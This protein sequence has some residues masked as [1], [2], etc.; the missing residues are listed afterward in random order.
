MLEQKLLNK[1][2]EIGE[3]FH[4]HQTTG[5]EQGVL[6]GET[7]LALF[8][9]YFSKFSKDETFS[10][11]G[12]NILEKSVEKV[13]S[14]YSLPT[15][16]A[17]I[18]GAAWVF[19]HLES[20]GFLAIDNDEF[21]PDLDK[22]IFTSMMVDIK[23]GNYDFLHGSLGNSY[24]FFYRFKNTKSKLLKEKYKDGILKFI[25]ELERISEFE[26]DRIKW[27]TKFDIKNNFTTY[28]LSLSHGISSIINFLSLLYTFE[29]FR[30]PVEKILLGSIN[31]V[32]SYYNKNRDTISLFPSYIRQN[33]DNQWNTR[34]AWCYGDL[35]IGL[36]LWKASRALNDIDLEKF[37]IDILSHTA[38]R[39]TPSNT[40]VNDSG[41]CH[42]SFGNAQV[43]T[44]LFRQTNI[45]EFQKS[46]QFWIEDGLNKLFHGDENAGHKKFTG[47][48]WEKELSLLDGIAGI[49]LAIMS[50]LDE[51][52]SSWDECLMIT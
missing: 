17:G 33:E 8:L 16:C 46:A 31:F 51:D 28:N 27:A 11:I 20:H 13:N 18:S 42:G 12:L 4:K 41:L 45:I 35:G 32:L 10:D 21:L 6:S 47:I 52:F 5:N 22:H 48:G 29:E 7:G 23:S 24:Y 1:L 49:G 34:V 50:Y 9:F 37:S 40:M 39:N 3:C 43:F 36:S 25:E 19:N 38:S 30:Q 15:F 26:G 14:G 44:Y 2:N